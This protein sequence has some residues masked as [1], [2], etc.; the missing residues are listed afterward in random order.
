MVVPW[1]VCVCVGG[2]RGVSERGEDLGW[3]GFPTHTHS[4]T[5]I[6]SHILIQEG[7]LIPLGSCSEHIFWQVFRRVM[8]LAG[9][10]LRQVSGTGRNW[11]QKSAV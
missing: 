11:Y 1:P 6:H 8:G 4:H 3:W 7:T 2:G 5:L 9:F 10:H